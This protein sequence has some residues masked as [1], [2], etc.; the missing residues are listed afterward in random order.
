MFFFKKPKKLDNLDLNNE[1]FYKQIN[2]ILY[3]RSI[4]SNALKLI[5]DNKNLQL[6]YNNMKRLWKT[7]GNKYMLECD[8]DT[9]QYILSNYDCTNDAQSY[10]QKKLLKY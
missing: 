7:F 4:L 8:K 3:N 6:D 2:G 1:V 9:Y 5:A 10:L